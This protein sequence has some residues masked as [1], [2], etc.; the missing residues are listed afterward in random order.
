MKYLF[1][2]IEVINWFLYGVITN[3]DFK[4][5]ER[6]RYEARD[7]EWDSCFHSIG[8]SNSG[9]KIWVSSQ[10]FKPWFPEFLRN[11]YYLCYKRNR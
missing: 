6:E 10:N 9:N 11:K 5:I 4:V 3:I 1:W 2:L 7:I 8:S